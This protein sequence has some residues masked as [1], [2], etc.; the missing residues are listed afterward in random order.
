MAKNN[1][2]RLC[3]KCMTEL[4]ITYDVYGNVTSIVCPNERCDKYKESNG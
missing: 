4:I 3:G 2:S 1:H